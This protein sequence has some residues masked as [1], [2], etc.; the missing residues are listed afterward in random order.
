M[1]HKNSTVEMNYAARRARCLIHRPILTGLMVP[2]RALGTSSFI[3]EFLKPTVVYRDTDRI[4]TKLNFQP[5][6]SANNS[7]CN[8]D[9]IHSSIVS[10]LME[11]SGSLCSIQAA[12]LNSNK[13]GRIKKYSASVVNLRA[14]HTKSAKNGKSYFI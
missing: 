12:E 6:F 2:R 13:N 8:S 4:D 9:A 10:A 1:Y 3:D 14:D 5:V 7:I 11:Y